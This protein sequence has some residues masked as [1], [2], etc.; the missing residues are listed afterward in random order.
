MKYTH[1]LIMTLIGL[2]VSSQA[3]VLWTTT[4]SGADG[5]DR[6]LSNTNGAGF[7][8]SITANDSN[9]TFE[10]VTF[11]GTVFM[12]SG[13][14]SSG[15]YYSPRTNVDNPAAGGGQNGGWWQTQFDYSGGTST[16]SLDSVVFDIV[17]SNSSGNFQTSDT[18]VR[19]ISFIVDYSLD[20]GSNWTSLGSQVID[21][22]ASTTSS[23]TIAATYSF[24]SPLTADLSGDQLSI[25][26]RAENANATSG[27]YV[28]IESIE[29]NGSV[30]PEPSS[31]ALIGLAGLGFILR[32]RR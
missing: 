27:A 25:R 18:V 30:V 6:S 1:T 11:S 21:T 24:G 10:D 3:A 5:T 31:T 29:F 4:F 15:I 17:R 23:P 14:L 12:H 2:T 28:N 13:T 19:D 7:T 16:I 8:D 32:R 9:L 26:V 20:G 22:T